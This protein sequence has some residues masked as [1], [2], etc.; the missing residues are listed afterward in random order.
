[1]LAEKRTGIGKGRIHFG[2]RG[3]MNADECWGRVQKK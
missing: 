2:G 1:M 3:E